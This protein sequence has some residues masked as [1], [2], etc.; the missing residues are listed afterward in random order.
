V[1]SGKT[2]LLNHVLPG[3]IAEDFAADPDPQKYYP[4]ILKHTFVHR[5]P[6]VAANNFHM[7]LNS[8]AEKLG[9]THAVEQVLSDALS[10]LSFTLNAL[11]AAIHQAGGLFWL[12]LDE[13]QV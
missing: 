4:V 2:T 10:E 9:L 13:F 7:C 6:V 5:S 8:F 12:L 1:K 3:R 11:A